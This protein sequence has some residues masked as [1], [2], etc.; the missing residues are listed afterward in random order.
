MTD[1]DGVGPPSDGVAD[2][3]LG[4]DDVGAPDGVPVVVVAAPLGM[5]PVAG[6][7]EGAAEPGAWPEGDAELLGVGLREGERLCDGAAVG[8][9][10][11]VG[12]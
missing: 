11:P 4:P 2:G 1:G 10:P 5:L 12:W 7:E 9:V 3:V 6:A 8:P